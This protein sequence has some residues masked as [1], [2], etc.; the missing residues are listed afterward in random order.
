[1]IKVALLLILCARSAMADFVTPLKSLEIS[2]PFGMR[3]DP[4]TREVTMHEGIDV[5]ADPGTP[6]YAVA[7]GKVVFS[8][9]YR[10]YGNLVVIRHNA[11]LTSHYGHLGGALPKV[12]SMVTEGQVIGTLG[13]S[14]R[15]TG[16]HLHFELRINGDA[17]DPVL[18]FQNHKI[19]KQ[20][21]E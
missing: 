6:I 8:G 14:G 7:A 10:G 2:S 18:Y 15:A 11:E 4:I 3:K 13:R 12:G 5:K 1:L 17:K 19:L 20:F 16:P 9:L 21:E